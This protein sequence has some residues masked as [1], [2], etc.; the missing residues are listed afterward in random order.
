MPG[1][2]VLS[3]TQRI[4]VLPNTSVSF[5][6]QGPTGP[7]GPQGIPGIQG[8]TGPTG[9][10]A[11]SE[12]NRVTRL[13]DVVI[14]STFG[15]ADSTLILPLAVGTYE[16]EGVLLYESDVTEDFKTTFGVSGGLV[17]SG[18]AVL[19]TGSPTTVTAFLTGSTG[20]NCPPSAF[21]T[22]YGL[23]GGAGNNIPLAL[24]LKG[25][26]VVTTAGSLIL[27]RGTSAGAGTLYKG[28]YIQSRKLS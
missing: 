11:S 12:W 3:R 24:F 4:I 23:F 2:E 10:V 6:K 5:V 28:S 18:G 21:E 27:W 22:I 7:Q 15:G 8:L 16:I 9:P 1:I 13:T 26:Y 25:I 20:F 17:V 14:D 19:F